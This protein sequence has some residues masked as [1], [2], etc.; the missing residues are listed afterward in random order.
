MMRRARA[1]RV[2]S[3]VNTAASPG[4]PGRWGRS[5]SRLVMSQPSG[6]RCAATATPCSTA[7]AR[8]TSACPWAAPARPRGWGSRPTTASPSPA[9]RAARRAGHW[10]GSGRGSLVLLGAP[11]RSWRPRPARPY[12]LAV[13]RRHG[14]H[15][16]VPPIIAPSPRAL[17]RRA[18]SMPDH[19]TAHESPSVPS[20][21][22]SRERSDRVDRSLG[23]RTLSSCPTGD[24]LDGRRQ[25]DHGASSSHHQGSD[26][27]DERLR[28][29]PYTGARPVAA[30]RSPGCSPEHPACG[31]AWM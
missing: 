20:S 1:R 25:D 21:H 18:E 5:P 11:F 13:A 4:A 12:F 23:V 3:G 29:F 26:R 17:A 9:R 14:G 2:N 30:S 28:S 15:A 8:P 6:R 10:I 19:R 31:S 27:A 16:A 22:P 24:G 7:P